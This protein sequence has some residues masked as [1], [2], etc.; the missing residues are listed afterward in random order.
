MCRC[1]FKKRKKVNF[2]LV[3]KLSSRDQTSATPGPFARGFP[4]PSIFQ[5]LRQVCNYAKLIKCVLGFLE[6][7]RGVVIVWK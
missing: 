2:Q 5:V 3:F 4:L 1:T 6:L 7:V